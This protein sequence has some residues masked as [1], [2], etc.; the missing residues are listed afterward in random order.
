[1]A[2]SA[3]PRDRTDAFNAA[4]DALRQYIRSGNADA[5]LVFE[6]AIYESFV[7]AVE[8]E[9]HYER[10]FA[11]W[12]D[13]MAALGRRFQAAQPQ[14]RAPSARRI[15]FVFHNGVVLGHTE[16]LFRLLEFRDR[17]GIEPRIYSLHGCMPD[18][19]Q[20]ATEL[21]VAVEVFP[22]AAA[23]AA[24]QGMVARLAW[25]RQSLAA[26][27]D[28]TAVWMSTPV[29]ST[30]AFAMRVAPVQV[31]SALRHH[32]VRLPEIDGYVTY[33]AWS[34]EE[35]IFHGQ[36]WAVCPVPLA[37]ESKRP[38]PEAVAAVRRR[39]AE[40]ILVGTIAR[41]EKID[42][43]TFLDSVAEILRR[44]PQ[45]G[46]IWTGQAI[47]AGIQAFFDARGI[48]YRCHFEG[49]V[50]TPLYTAALD[51]FLESFPLGCGITGYQAIAAGVPLVSYLEANTI[52][53][54]QYWKDVLDR[55]GSRGNATRALLD[56]YP[57]LCARD[58]ADYVELASRV[59]ADRPFA[60]AVKER[61]ARFYAEEIRDIGRYSRRYF[62]T[63]LGVAARKL[64]P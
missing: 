41:T 54:M 17:E 43:E 29:T 14:L 34:E 19:A 48:G 23:G 7:K 35:R 10:C 62:D 36:R 24:P 49:W 16:V 3:R 61:Q 6:I 44:N 26:N 64:N 40:P 18:F 55:A 11:L 51:V 37:L 27:G 31:F 42:S 28:A 15:G 57:V 56:E 45:C 39:F 38:A 50:D 22:E 13:E 59:V 58:P 30:F 32:P 9:D 25:L 46:F 12:R 63:L 4:V 8:E 60:A 21:G 2:S 5:A 47:H 1:M 53:G 20:R 52:F 33:G